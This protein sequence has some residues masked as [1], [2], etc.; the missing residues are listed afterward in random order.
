MTYEPDPADPGRCA[1]CGHSA[2]KHD[3]WPACDD[4]GTFS[5]D[6]LVLVQFPLPGQDSDRETWPW[7]PGII[8]A[9]GGE[10][11]WQVVVLDERLERNGTYPLAYR[12]ASDLRP[13]PAR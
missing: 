3:P 1:R 12:D 9:D 10:D 13:R 8:T 7:L 11:E 2:A 4:G 5:V 6:A